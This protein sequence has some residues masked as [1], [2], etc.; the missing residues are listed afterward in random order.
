[1]SKRTER[2][3]ASLPTAR[4]DA[5][6]AAG[7]SS[8]PQTRSAAYRLAYTDVDFLMRDEARPLRLQLELLKPE[9]ELQDQRV[10]STI[11]VF[12]SARI[13]DPETAA[14][15]LV[16]A[17]RARA[18]APADPRAQA[19]V[20][21]CRRALDRSHYYAE[22]RRFARIVSEQTQDAK[23]RCFVI[24]TGGGPGIMEAANR[25][26]ADVDAVSIG[27]SITLPHEEAPNLYITPE[28]SF[29][30]HYFALRKMHFLLRA[31]ALV[32]FPG[33]FGTFDELFETLCLIQTKKIRP[34]PVMLFGRAFWERVIDFEALVD[35]GVIGRDDLALFSFVETAEDAWS[36]ICAHYDGLV[37]EF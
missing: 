27:L 14:Q 15:N 30:F 22:A 19:A 6:R 36:R 28:L 10:E 12:G 32:V 31:R 25:G 5:V 1:M 23:S 34:M 8:T 3:H 20:E 24:V 11:V 17:E 35:E 37:C 26:A 4:E 13:A 18:A 29:Q 7:T 16:D 2:D 21:R 9:L 33:G